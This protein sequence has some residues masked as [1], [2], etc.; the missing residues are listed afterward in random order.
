MRLRS[1]WA[2]W[3]GRM[4]RC[5]YWWF[6]RRAMTSRFMC[7]PFIKDHK[8]NSHQIGH[9]Y[10]PGMFSRCPRVQLKQIGSGEY[11]GACIDALLG[12]PWHIVS[13]LFALS[14]V[15]QDKSFSNLQLTLPRY[16]LSM[17]SC[18][19]EA[20]LLG[21]CWGAYIHALVGGSKLIFFIFLIRWQCLHYPSLPLVFAREWQKYVRASLQCPYALSVCPLWCF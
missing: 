14:T 9:W 15:L 12:P 2:H 4:V 19:C 16:V 10:I 11:W 8:V 5:V 18:I 1:Y 3:L 20:H 17:P 7:L 21:D 13:L 6:G